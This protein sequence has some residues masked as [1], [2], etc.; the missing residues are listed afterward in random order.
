VR[1]IAPIAPSGV[2]D[3]TARLIG[4]WLS[5]R[6]GQQFV[7]DNRP[8]GGGNV[9]TEVVVR[10]PEKLFSTPGISDEKRAGS[11]AARRRALNFA[12]TPAGGGGRIQGRGSSARRQKSSDCWSGSSGAPQAG[13]GEYLR[14]DEEESFLR[15]CMRRRNMAI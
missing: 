8:G 2:T 15:V 6:I 14:C 9:G 1:L 4:Q 5:E 7:I 13:R 3:I 12:P 10:A 11:I